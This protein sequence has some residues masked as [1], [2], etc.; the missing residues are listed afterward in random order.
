MTNSMTASIV[1]PTFNGRYKIE[2][3]LT[4]LSVQ[5]FTDY[6]IIV[7][8]DGSTDDT[9]SFIKSNPWKIEFLKIINQENKGR[10]IVRNRGARDAKGDVLIFIDDDMEIAQ[11]C[12]QAHMSLLGEKPDIISVGRQL[13]S[14][15]S[16]KTDFQNF[17]AFLSTRW[18]ENLLTQS[19]P[20]TQKSI[21]L[22]AA[23]FALKKET[24]KKVS[25]FNEELT[26]AEDFDLAMRAYQ[27]NISLYFNHGAIAFHHDPV[28]CQ[29]YA[30]RLQQYKTAHLRLISIHGDAL[31][32]FNVPKYKPYKG[33]KRLIYRFFS[34]PIWIRTIDGF[35][36]L[37]ILPQKWRY[38]IYEIIIT[39]QT[40]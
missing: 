19:N 33:L 9:F 17:K 29:Q 37:R 39:A 16:K 31:N 27:Q 2:R 13:D 36:W 8:I 14:E 4:S 30:M 1:I 24:F 32:D 21:F 23:N 40:I 12:I 5:S 10:S 6:E 20:L 28:T 11:D 7:V 38:K 3:L 18:E 22:T 35:N 34:L 26:D 15:S 25:G